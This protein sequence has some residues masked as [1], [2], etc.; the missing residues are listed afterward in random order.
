MRMAT[1]ETSSLDDGEFAIPSR[2]GGPLIVARRDGDHVT[3]AANTRNPGE[4]AYIAPAEARD[5][6]AALT[7]LARLAETGGDIPDGPDLTGEPT[8]L[9]EV[10]VSAWGD[11]AALVRQVL[12]QQTDLAGFHQLEENPDK[13]WMAQALAVIAGDLLGELTEALARLNQFGKKST[14]REILAERIDI[15]RRTQNRRTGS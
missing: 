8:I 7:Y 12:E 10:K 11:A 15:I 1:A 9:D 3:V 13:A 5:L 6:G 2:H 14:P 4:P